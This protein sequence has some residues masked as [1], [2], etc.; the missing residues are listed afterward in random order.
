[1][2][3]VHSGAVGPQVALGAEH[4]GVARIPL[5][6]RIWTRVGGSSGPL[7][8]KYTCALHLS[9]AFNRSNPT[10]QQHTGIHQASTKAQTNS[11]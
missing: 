7:H 11:P 5:G 8:C 4:R 9:A 1:M 10:P 3:G 6:L 2:G